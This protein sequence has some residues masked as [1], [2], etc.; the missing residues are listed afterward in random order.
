MAKE[1]LPKGFASFV[2]SQ[3]P[4]PICAYSLRL[5]VLGSG[6]F[7]IHSILPLGSVF[8]LNVCDFFK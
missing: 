5:F 6:Y 8:P 4:M 7:A 1:P 3:K 2:I